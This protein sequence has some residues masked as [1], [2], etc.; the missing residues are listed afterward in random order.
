MSASP[1]ESKNDANESYEINNNQTTE[2]QAP[3]NLQDA[4][5]PIQP[6]YFPPEPIIEPKTP[7]TPPPETTP[8]IIRATETSQ[9]NDDNIGNILSNVITPSFL[10]G[11]GAVG[12][13]AIG[14]NAPRKQVQITPE[15]GTT[16]VS[17]D[18]LPSVNL[19]VGT[20]F[21]LY[22][23]IVVMLATLIGSTGVLSLN[24]VPK[25]EERAKTWQI[26]IIC[27][28]FFP[29]AI[30]AIIQNQFLGGQQ[31]S[32]ETLIAEQE[33]NLVLQNATIEEIQLELQQAHRQLRLSTEII[34]APELYSFP[35]QNLVIGNQQSIAELDRLRIELE[36]MKK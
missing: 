26:G 16:T 21:F 22:S 28:L 36:E 18:Y 33:E 29:T 15:D 19:G 9:N 8:T 32:V 1:E 20:E 7:Q 23:C 13:I 27:A 17:Q 30:S 10:G 6:V 4:G 3:D 5:E 12:L 2:N 11:V 25:K 24:G 34:A 35:Q 31:A 14:L